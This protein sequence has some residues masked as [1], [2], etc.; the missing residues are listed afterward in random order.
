[1]QQT[2]VV[3]SL[4]DG[5]GTGH[6]VLNFLEIKH[7]YVS[8]E[9]CPIKRKIADHNSVG[10][11]RPVSDIYEVLKWL[12]DNLEITKRI[13]LVLCGFSC[14][15]L[16][17]QGNRKLWDGESKIFFECV[18]ILDFLKS[19]NPRIKFF[20]ENVAS[21]PNECRDL[22]SKLLKVDFYRLDAGLVSPQ[23]RVRYFW[24]NWDKK[25]EVVRREIYAKDYL[26]DD[27]LEVVA[28][29]KSNRGKDENGKSIV[30]GRTRVDGKAATLVTGKGCSGQS[31]K[32]F[33]ITKQMKIRDPSVQECLNWQSIPFFDL[34]IVSD[35][36]AFEAIGDGWQFDAVKLII[37][38][39]YD[40]YNSL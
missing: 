32:N 36:N 37:G 30:E 8:I 23:G 25:V 2:E 1:M 4:A 28:F 33:V 12:M 20:F 17:S 24:F 16:S 13:T 39:K 29:S 34:S 26:D 22:I 38:W 31:T 6:H 7:E 15:S 9:N 18:K 40:Y 10:F 3:L 35:A 5:I 11:I 21:M 14:K 27:G 19:I